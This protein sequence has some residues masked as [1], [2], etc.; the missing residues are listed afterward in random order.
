MIDFKIL[1]HI[2]DNEFIKYINDF[3]IKNDFINQPYFLKNENLN[4]LDLKKR[5]SFY[6]ILNDGNITQKL[7]KILKKI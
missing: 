1:D 3:I 2:I 6:M 4:F 7:L 5:N